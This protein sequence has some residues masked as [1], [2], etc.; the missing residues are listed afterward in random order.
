ME[1]FAI[2]LGNKQTKMISSKTLANEVNGCKVFPSVFSYYENLGD[3]VTVFGTQKNVSKY[4]T[5]KDIDTEYAWGKEINKIKKLKLMD[6]L[7]FSS[8]RYEMREFRLLA[9]FAIGELAKDFEEAKDGILE[10]MV[11]TGIPSKDYNKDS[12]EKLK[13]VFMGDHQVSIDGISYNVRV[14]DVKVMNQ[15]IGTI[16]N[17]ILDFNGNVTDQSYLSETITIVDI[18]GGTF[19]VDTLNEMMMDHGMSDTEYTGAID[20][21]ENIRKKLAQAKGFSLSVYEVEDILRNSK[22]D[23]YYY[24]RNSNEIYPITQ[25]VDEI[26]RQYTTER[27]NRINAIVKDT[28]IISKFLVTGGGSNLISKTEFENALKY[29]KFINNPE[30]ANAMGFYKAGVRYL[31]EIKQGV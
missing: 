14:K 12:V 22:N 31:K 15:P 8:D 30:T 24:K 6:T 26:K 19:I 18:G 5:S 23:E 16:Y 2:D 21:Y 4:Q 7:K 27:I 25:Y 9:T 20:L 11:I 3:R 13:K 29:V 1:I 28:S 10:V 17:E